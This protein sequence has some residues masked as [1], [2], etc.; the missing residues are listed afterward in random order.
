LVEPQLLS[1]ICQ[2]IK[3]VL[4]NPTIQLEPQ[5]SDSSFL[6]KLFPFKDEKKM[7]DLWLQDLVSM[8]KTFLSDAQ[9]K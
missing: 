1:G 8:L 2:V 6:M 9:G 3:F 7:I 5:V 4:L